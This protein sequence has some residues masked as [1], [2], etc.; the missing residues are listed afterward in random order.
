MTL[1]VLANEAENCTSCVLSETRSR[2]VFSSGPPEAE[3]FFVGEAPGASEDETGLPFVGRSGRLVERLCDEELGLSRDQVYIA[4]VLK[5]RPP[6]NRDPKPVE[7]A[8]CKR[9]LESQL[10]LVNPKVLVPVGNFA[11]RFILGTKL[12]IT[13]LRGNVYRS[14]STFVVP[15]YHPAAVLRGGAARLSEMSDD[16]RVVANIL[17][18]EAVVTSDKP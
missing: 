16:F 11:T 1:S 18:G 14:G 5:C 15:T 6:E 2:V 12:G 7:I 17:N 8:A 10:S 9:F 13:K 4:N 3:V